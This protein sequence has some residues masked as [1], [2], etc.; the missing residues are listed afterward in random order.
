METTARWRSMVWVQELDRLVEPRALSHAHSLPFGPSHMRRPGHGSSA[1][2]PL[3]QVAAPHP[4]GPPAARG[5]GTGVLPLVVRGRE[6][7]GRRDPRRA[8]AWR[9]GGWSSRTG[10]ARLPARVPSPGFGLALAQRLGPEPEV[11]ASRHLVLAQ[12]GD[13]RGPVAGHLTGRRPVAQL[14]QVRLG[15]HAGEVG[16]RVGPKGQ[17]VGPGDA[18]VLVDPHHRRHVRD[19]VELGQDVLGVDEGPGW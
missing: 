9:P 10:Q 18:V 3:N 17:G 7:A 13:D 19:G 2:A 5:R 4:A 8:A 16:E 12:V 11:Q 6:S 15:G 1:R 14:A